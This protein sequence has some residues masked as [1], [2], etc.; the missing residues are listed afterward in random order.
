MAFSRM[1]LLVK[2]LGRIIESGLLMETTNHRRAIRRPYSGKGS[3]ASRKMELT[4]P[5]RK[6]HGADTIDLIGKVFSGWRDYF[7]FRDCLR[8][9]IY[10]GHYDWEASRIGIIDGQVVTHWGVWGYDMRIGT[11]R[12]RIGGIG[13]VAT[14]KDFR[15]RGL[16]VKTACASIDAMRRMGYDMTILFGIDNF[17]H[18]FG[19]V[20]A[21]SEI[22]YCVK[23]DDLPKDGLDVKLHKFALR[24]RD[25]LDKIYNRE[26]SRSTGTAVRPTY[27]KD[28]YIDKCAG[29]LWRDKRGKTAGY[30]VLGSTDGKFF[31]YECGGDVEQA[32]RAIA[33]IVRKLGH[34]EVRF[35]TGLHYDSALSKRLR[36]G[37]CRVEISHSRCGQ[38]M[39]RMLNL[40]STL[41]KTS[42]ELSRRLSKSHL[43]GWRGDL[44]L[45][46]AREKALLTITGSKISVARP[47]TSKNCIRGGEEIVQLII[48][49]D[50]PEEIV[51]AGK[52]RVTGEAK[53]LLP[54]LF[55][56]QHATLAAWDRY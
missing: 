44:L 4:A 20:R 3:M 56:N 10:H 36:R 5:D 45:S 26:N 33:K 29:Y 15:K 40:E 24:Q 41:R 42:G 2:T 34:K 11:A 25:D 9:R 27:I 16:M 49:T 28:R 47:G 53:K 32:L 43:A 38:A 17:Y 14:H 1:F 39:V 54:V 19:Y 31:C 35:A 7:V 8:N 52:I 12:V 46:D 48:G 18:R 6:K 23:V 55:P 51:E 22:E 37:N 30:V 50:E 13:V 21:W